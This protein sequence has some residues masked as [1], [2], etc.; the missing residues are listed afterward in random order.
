MA[1]KKKNCRLTLILL[2]SLSLTTFRSR[3]QENIAAETQLENQTA[4]A[5]LPDDD[6]HWQQL[7]SFSRH[8]IDLNKADA[9]TLTALGILDPLQVTQLLNYRRLMGP[10]LAIYELQAIPGYD[11]SVIIQ[12]LPYVT[13][14][15][16]TQAVTPR[17]YLR[18][19]THQLLIRYDRQLPAPRGY[20]RTDTTAAHYTG[21]P[22]QLLLRYRYSLPRHISWGL[23]ME[24]DAGEQLFKGTQKQG[25]DFYSAHLFLRD[26]K[27]IKA[28]AIGDFTAN[29]GQGLLN[30]QALAFDKSAAVMQIKREGD[31]L[32]PYASAGEFNFFRGAGITLQQK[33]W[34]LTAFGSSRRLDGNLVSTD[35]LEWITAFTTS[36][37]HRSINE[38]TKKGTVRQLTAGANL[39]YHRDNWHIGLNMIAH[40]LSAPLQKATAAYNRFTF[41]GN[42]LLAGSID[43]ALTWKNIHYF[44]EIAMSSNRKPAVVMGAL[45]SVAPAVDIAVLYRSYHRAYQSLYAHAFGES[46]QNVNEQGIY[47]ALRLKLHQRLYLDAFADRYRFPWLKYRIN[48]PSAGS[49]YLLAFTYTPRKQITCYFAWHVQQRPIA[50]EDDSSFIRPVNKAIEKSIRLQTSFPLGKYLICRTR[51]EWQYINKNAMIQQGGVIYVELRYK[52]LNS[53]WRWSARGTRFNTGGS[54]NRLYITEGG[55]LY[56]YAVAQLSGRGWQYY[57]QGEW[58]CNRRITAWIRWH[59]TLY[60]DR[61][62]IGSGWDRINGAA[63]HTFQCQW[64]YLF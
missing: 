53:H 39:S 41:H 9:A 36:G 23:L 49:E 8:K 50:A 28:L 15:D 44:G 10:F 19:G 16:A 58:K 46:Y 63:K 31:I 38:N 22:D 54:D 12:L 25:F 11:T 48:A 21:S 27:H 64:Q 6:N 24:K 37:Y 57:L 14:N 20:H 32:R 17:D 30:W 62:F 4:R 5:E 59:Q 51:A 33:A 18:K 45:A 26:Y 42:K 40:Q 43:Y 56:N 3:A 52:P 60:E 13:V 7:Q 2:L 1:T 34:Q 47:A 61:Q 55:M 35:T 29:L